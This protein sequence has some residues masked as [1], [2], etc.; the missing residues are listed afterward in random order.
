[1]L[2]AVVRA[3]ASL[4]PTLVETDMRAVVGQV[5]R[6]LRKRSLVVLFTA[7]EPAAVNE[8]LLPAIGPLTQR[9]VVV[10]AAVSDPRLATLRAGRGDSAAVYA[11][12][13]AEAAEADRRNVGWG[14]RR[15]GVVVTEAEPDLFASHVADT[16]LDLKAAGRL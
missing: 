5:L 10:V 3:T 15:R 2:A 1:S 16:Y 14:L 7:L 13:A 8:G 9:H 6:R 11:A 12:A 4:E